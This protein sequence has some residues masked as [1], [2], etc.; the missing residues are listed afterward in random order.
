MF[1]TANSPIILGFKWLQQH[2]PHINWLDRQIASWS[3][4][5]HSFCLRSV[6]PPGPPPA[7]PQEADPPDLSIIPSEY[8]DLASVFSKSKALSSPPHRPY[9]CAIDLLPG[10]P[11]PSSRLYNIS[12]SERETME[13]Y[14]KESL[15]AGIIRPSL[16]S[17]GGGVFLCG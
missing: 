9:D 6:V 8:H 5:C 14:I 4:S 7:A 13:K 1:S 15:A 11:L 2:N 17:P 3:I 10:A 12:R 16:L